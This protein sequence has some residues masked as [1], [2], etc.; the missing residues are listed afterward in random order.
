[1]ALQGPRAEEVLARLDP[2]AAQL[3]FMRAAPLHL[4]GSEC[5]ATRSGYTGEDGFEISVAAQHAEALARMLL[6]DP[7][8]KP[9]G[10]GARDTLRLE[11]GL[12]LY[13]Q[14][15]DANT[16]PHE[17]ALE[18]AIAKARRAGGPK[19]GGYPGAQTV[20]RE[21]SQGVSRRLGGFM[22]QGKV[23]VRHGAPIVDAGG[24]EVGMVTSGTVSPSLGKPVMLGYAA[25]TGPDRE[26]FALVRGERQPIARATLPFIPKRYKR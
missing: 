14:D 26:L 25:A 10:L 15:M 18:W 8:V 1:V 3:G 24:K 7:A 4:A 16:T 22:G 9:A 21:E 2:R 5:F 19:A 17:A 20:L 12:H 23:P 13:G 11:A 6:A